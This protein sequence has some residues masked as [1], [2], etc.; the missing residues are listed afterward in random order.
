VNNLN[1]DSIA[2]QESAN[3]LPGSNAA[4]LESVSLV[5]VFQRRPERDRA[6]KGIS[7]SGYDIHWPDGQ[8]VTLGLRRFCNQGTR[9]LLGRA[10]G[11][12]RALVRVTMHPVEGVEADLTRPGPGIRCRRFFAMREA[13][14]IRFHFFTG[15][16]TEIVFDERDDDPRVLHWLHSRHISAHAPFWFDLASELLPESGA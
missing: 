10:R 3:D 13:D 11:R 6:E 7:F 8:P 12:E 5:V 4:R 16:R 2:R 14:E 15:D 1:C 9:L